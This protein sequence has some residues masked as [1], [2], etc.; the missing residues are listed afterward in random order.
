MGDLG[1]FIIEHVRSKDSLIKQEEMLELGN[2]VIEESK[3]EAPSIKEQD[4]TP[5]P[6]IRG[7]K[8]HKQENEDML[9][10]LTLKE[11]QCPF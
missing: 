10:I 11:L 9:A 3:E 2:R 5:Q 1:N 8:D 7:T 6:H 4:L